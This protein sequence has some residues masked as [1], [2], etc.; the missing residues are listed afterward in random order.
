MQYTSYLQTNALPKRLQFLRSKLER[1]QRLHFPYC[2]LQKRITAITYHINATVLAMVY[3]I[4]PHY[5]I[6]SSPYLDAGQC[7][8]VYIIMLH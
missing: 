6:A 7:I 4:S 3:P 8:A 5:G 2:G 1:K